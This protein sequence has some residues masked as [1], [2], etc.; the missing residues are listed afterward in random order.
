ML[1][2]KLNDRVVEIVKVQSTVGFSEDKNWVL[3]NLKL[4]DKISLEV[5]WLPVASTRFE[6]VRECHL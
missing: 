5:K 3:I 6:W 1:I 2:G 4:G